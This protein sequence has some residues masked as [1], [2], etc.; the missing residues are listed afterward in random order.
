MHNIITY[1]FATYVRM[2]AHTCTEKSKNDEFKKGV[3]I[4]FAIIGKEIRYQ[5][6]ALSNGYYYRYKY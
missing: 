1:T 6:P 5:L 3:G 4:S 2:Y